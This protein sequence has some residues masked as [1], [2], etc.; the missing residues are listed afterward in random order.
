MHCLYIEWLHYLLRPFEKPCTR[1]GAQA[2]EVE[3]VIK[4]AETSRSGR[5]KLKRRKEIIFNE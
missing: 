4:H 3:R 2:T 5:E 1:V